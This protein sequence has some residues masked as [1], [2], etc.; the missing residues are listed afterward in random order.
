MVHTAQSAISQTHRAVTVLDPKTFILDSNIYKVIHQTSHLAY[1][2]FTFTTIVEV[3]TYSVLF[4]V[5]YETNYRIVDFS[6]LLLYCGCASSC[7]VEYFTLIIWILKDKS[8]VIKFL[9]NF[10]WAFCCLIHG[11]FV[12]FFHGAVLLQVG[13]LGWLTGWLK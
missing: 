11:A 7:T 3:R 4:F 12:P 5:Y 6:F 13:S 8:T 9:I 10:V 1:V 2:W